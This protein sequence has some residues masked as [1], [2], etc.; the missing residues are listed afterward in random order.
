MVEIKICVYGVLAM[1]CLFAIV[2]FAMYCV[3]CHVC[4][5]VFAMFV[6]AMLC[7]YTKLVRSSRVVVCYSQVV[8]WLRYVGI[9]ISSPCGVMPFGT[10]S[11]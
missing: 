8:P 5:F 7:K 4:V 3:F 1:L 6:L 11:F 9:V 10:V 2:V